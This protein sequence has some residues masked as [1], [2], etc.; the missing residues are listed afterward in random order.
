[1]TENI[2]EEVLGEV[3][4][5]LEGDYWVAF[6]EVADYLNKTNITKRDQKE[7]LMDT[8]I[9]LNEA[10]INDRPVAN[11]VG[12]DISKYCRDIIKEIKPYMSTGDKVK[13]FIE[14]LLIA[15][16]GILIYLSTV[17][18]LSSIIGKGDIFTENGS[19]IVNMRLLLAPAIGIIW[20]IIY[21]KISK[22]YKSSNT[23]KKVS[24]FLGLLAIL[25]LVSLIILSIFENILESGITIRPVFLYLLNVFMIVVTIF[26]SKKLDKERP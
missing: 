23:W 14:G 18:L 21:G 3:A 9:M 26:Y 11:V 25:F 2:Y 8:A 22:N 20:V 5:D 10:M 15:I 16:T 19:V 7:I 17:T 1:M 24:I 6:V 13:I 12:K 4:V